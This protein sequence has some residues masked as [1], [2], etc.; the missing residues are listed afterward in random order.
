MMGAGHC[1]LFVR[2]ET[3][4]ALITTT[5]HTAHVCAVETLKLGLRAGGTPPPPVCLC[6]LVFFWGGG[7]RLGES[8]GEYTCATG[9]GR[10]SSAL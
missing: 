7:G 8:D 3:A 10:I 4:H 1:D 6:F 9:P 2:L 5:Q